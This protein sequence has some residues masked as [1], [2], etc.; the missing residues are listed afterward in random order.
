M[1]DKRF[2]G[3]FVIPIAISICAVAA[4]V[5][6]IAAAQTGDTSGIWPALAVAA[7]AILISIAVAYRT[8]RLQSRETV[9]LF[10]WVLRAEKLAKPG[11]RQ[12][13][14]PVLDRIAAVV[15]E[16]LSQSVKD[17]AQLFAII[18]SMSDG[19]IATDHEQRILLTNAAAEELM[20]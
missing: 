7:C 2:L 18:A 6:A 13:D 3:R 11:G 14:E 9:E 8:Q 5:A 17:Q 12:D 20:C 1:V 19:L 15:R 16:L 10:G 4:I